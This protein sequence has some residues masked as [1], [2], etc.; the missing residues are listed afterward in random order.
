[1]LPEIN[2]FGFISVSGYLFFILFGIILG[3]MVVVFLS[4]RENL[5]TI[6]TINFLIFAVIFG[7]IGSKLYALMFTLVKNPVNY[8]NNMQKLWDS[9]K[10]GG[11]YYGC[12]IFLII[13]SI[14]YTRKFFKENSWKLFDITVIGL[15]LAQIFGRIGCFAAGC[16]FGKPTSLLIGMEFPY[17]SGKPHPFANIPVHP[18]QVYLAI[19]N[20]VNFILLSVIWRKRKFQGQVCACY[21]INYGIIR[22]LV[23][24]LRND[25]GRGYLFKGNSIFLTLS[26]PQF[27][28]IL[29]IIAGIIIFKKRN[30]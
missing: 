28:S 30:L 13:Y 2:I 1:M 18:T 7:A 22:F 15:A 5:D 20:L 11:V 25:G 4:R 10:N 17:L 23:E 19:L 6:E 24:Y 8:L 14:V 27:I 26:I 12:F 21:L 16:C 9:L 3:F 29:L